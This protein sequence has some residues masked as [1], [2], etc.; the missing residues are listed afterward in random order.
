MT[1]II[2]RVFASEAQARK[3]ADRLNVKFLPRRNVRIING[4]PNAEAEMQRA[5]V[6]ESA[7]TPY[8]KHLAKGAAVLAVRAGSKPLGAARITREVMAKFETHDVGNAVEESKVAWTPDKSPSIL[9]DH[10]L[11]L[12]NAGVASAGPVSEGLSLPMLKERKSKRSVMSGEKRMS[13]MFWPMPLLKTN[14]NAT[15]AISGGRYM[16]RMFWPMK[17]LST[18]PRRK[19]VIPGGGFPFSRRFGLKTTI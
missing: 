16:S 14:R 9:K 17:L 6:H 5:Q 8:A 11:F 12:T 15:S 7:I 1:K 2:T 19:S 13:R 10:P 18:K 4:G 3:A